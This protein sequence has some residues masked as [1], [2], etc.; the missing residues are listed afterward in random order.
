[1]VDYKYFAL[2]PSGIS[3]IRFTLKDACADAIFDIKNGYAT[4]YAIY[5][6][7]FARV[8]FAGI[9]EKKGTTYKFVIP[10]SSSK[11]LNKDGS[12]RKTPEPKPFLR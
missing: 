10:G 3:A 7:S 11:V 6:V 5:K 1:M 8:V 4:S 12:F 2:M 9:V